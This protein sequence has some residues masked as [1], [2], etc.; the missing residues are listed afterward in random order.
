MA[1]IPSPIQ[2]IFDPLFEQKGI[3]VY[4]KRE[5]LIHPIIMGN[6][7]RKHK[8]NIEEALKKG[9]GQIVT[10]GGAYS[11]HIVAT[12]A[13]AKD[14]NLK[15]IGIIRGDELKPDSNPT[16]INAAALGMGFEFVSREEYEILRNDIRQLQSSYPMSFLIPEG[17]TN[18]LAIK[19]CEEMVAEINIDYDYICAPI[20]TGGTMVG[21]LQGLSQEKV[22]IGVSSLKGDFIHQMVSDLLMTHRI[23]KKNY[24]IMDQYHFGGYGKVKDE[25][26]DF[27]NDFKRKH[28]ILLDPI[29]TGKMFYGVIDLIKQDYFKFNRRI[30]LIHT[31]GIQGIEGYNSKNRRKIS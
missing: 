18:E 22:I 19:G 20:G 6:K 13:A 30:I 21:I 3:R 10:L 8:Y 23:E 24:E 11:N 17:G 12:A 14:N 4:V 5:D 25:L 27:I 15:S 2:E 16:L 29:Y 26:I 7:W 28:Q 1:L 9:F 31:G